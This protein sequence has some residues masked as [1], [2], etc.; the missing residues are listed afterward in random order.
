MYNSCIDCELGEEEYEMLQ[1]FQADENE[2]RVMEAKKIA[3]DYGFKASEAGMICAPAVN[4][5]FM[6]WYR[7][8]QDL[9]FIAM[10]TNWHKGFLTHLQEAVA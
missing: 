1:A 2:F 5:E 3:Y 6:N 9:D 4:K 8:N 7:E 10:L